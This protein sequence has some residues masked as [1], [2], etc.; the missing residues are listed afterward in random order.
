MESSRP[1]ADLLAEKL[2]LAKIREEELRLEKIQKTLFQM[3]QNHI[4][5]NWASAVSGVEYTKKTRRLLYFGIP[6]KFRGEVWKKAIGNE[7]Q[8]KEQSYYLALERARE[9]EVRGVNQ[10][11]D[12]KWGL[13]EAAETDM[14][15]SF[16]ELKMFQRGMLLHED[17]VDVVKAYIMYRSDVKVIF[18][19]HVSIPFI[20]LRL[21]CVLSIQY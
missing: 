17:L 19:I 14:E 4:I 9:W 10:E 3:W 8:L 18:G 21:V 2:R 1:S 5:P 15:F 7:L 16:P 11:R 13:I 6:T 12:E 20:S